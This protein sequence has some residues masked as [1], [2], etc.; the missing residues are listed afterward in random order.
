MV[1]TAARRPGSEAPT[2]EQFTQR[3]ALRDWTAGLALFLA[4]VCVV[5]WQ[6]AHVAILWDTSYVLDSACAFAH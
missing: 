5:L 2:P 3:F 4:T 1:R 6:N